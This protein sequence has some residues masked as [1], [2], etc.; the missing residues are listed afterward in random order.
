MY[1]PY[2]DKQKYYLHYMNREIIKGYHSFIELYQVSFTRTKDRES[3][4]K[5]AAKM[6]KSKQHIN[7]N[8]YVYI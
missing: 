5:Q 3:K 2:Q 6:C 1:Y 4:A 7:K 8:I